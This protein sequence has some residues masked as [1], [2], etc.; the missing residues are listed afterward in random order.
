MLLKTILLVS[1]C[2]AFV[3][4]P[5]WSFDHPC[6]TYT[7]N[8]FRKSPTCRCSSSMNQEDSDDVDSLVATSSSLDDT[9]PIL[10]T[11]SEGIGTRE[12]TYPQARL[13]WKRRLQAALPGRHADS[14]EGVDR[15]ILTTA[16]PSM[17]NL[18]VVPLVNAVDTFYVGRL[19]VALALAGQVRV[20][21]RCSCCTFAIFVLT[22]FLSNAARAPPINLSSLC[23]SLWLS[24][25]HSRRPWWPLQQGRGILKKHDAVFARVFFCATYLA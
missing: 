20:D 7:R 15:L 13:G 23:T 2:W 6:R 4:R 17:I 10:M 14:V 21:L 22:C 19:G 25:P 9:S 8:V 11:D 24:C 5:L 1:P 18:A 12:E 3:S 16:I